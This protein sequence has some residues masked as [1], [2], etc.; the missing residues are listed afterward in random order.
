MLGR[1]PKK[2]CAEISQKFSQLQT[3]L[4]QATAFIEAITRGELAQEIDYKAFEE[5]KALAEA[6]Q[7]MRAQMQSFNQTE[8]QR[9]WVI[10]GQAQFSELLRHYN[11]DIQE[12]SDQLLKF[13]VHYTGAIQGG[14]FILNDEKPNESYLEMKAC[15][16]YDRKKYIRRIVPIEEGFAEGLVGQVFL[17]GHLTYLREVPQDYTRITSGLGEATA[18][19]LVIVP[20]KTNEATLGVLELA[21]FQAFE[22]YQLEFWKK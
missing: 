5:A 13:L 8:R 6:L 3:E 21:A 7:A 11:Q 14:V 17:E 10:E 2:A 12:L 1:V 15:Y 4:Q 22:K 19:H 16:A 20:L 18:S 9:N